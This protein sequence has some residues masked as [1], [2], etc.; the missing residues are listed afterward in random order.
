MRGDGKP[1]EICHD[2]QIVIAAGGR[3]RKI[4]RNGLS[5]SQGHALRGGVELSG[6]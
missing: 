6:V 1:G 2:G 4:A 5:G 3:K